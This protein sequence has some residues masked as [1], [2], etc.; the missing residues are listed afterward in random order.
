MR[1]SREGG[2]YGPSEHGLVICSRFPIASVGH[3]LV[4]P[5]E[6][7]PTFSDMPSSVKSDLFWLLDSFI[8]QNK[9]EDRLCGDEYPV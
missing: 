2:V 6:H 8:V 4:I 5:K 3:F 7:Y 1:E 9:G